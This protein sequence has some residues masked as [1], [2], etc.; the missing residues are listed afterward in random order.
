MTNQQASPWRRPADKPPHGTPALLAL[1]IGTN[2]GAGL[3]EAWAIAWFDEPAGVW[4]DVS[5]GNTVDPPWIVGWRPL[6]DRPPWE[7][8]P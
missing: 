4:G 6:D 5:T 8:A 3:D 1:Y 7:E 2:T